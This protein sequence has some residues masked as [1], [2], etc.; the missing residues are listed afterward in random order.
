MSGCP[1]RVYATLEEIMVVI[2]EFQYQHEAQFARGIL[3]EA[4]IGAAVIVPSAGLAGYALALP[5]TVPLLVNE[6]DVVLA[7]QVLTESGVN[8]R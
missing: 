1:V 6:E 2:A 5:N 3:E 8:I 7:R 4:G